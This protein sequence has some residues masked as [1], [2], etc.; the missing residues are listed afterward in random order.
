MK[1]IEVKLKDTHTDGSLVRNQLTVNLET[2][3]D[4]CGDQGHDLLLFRAALSLI[5]LVY[6]SS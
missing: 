4:L 3:C 2:E 1:E 6:L 5:V